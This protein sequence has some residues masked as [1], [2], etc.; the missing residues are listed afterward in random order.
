MCSSS[1]DAPTAKTPIHVFLVIPHV[2]STLLVTRGGPC[3]LLVTLMS[4]YR[5]RRENSEFI[6]KHSD[7]P[8]LR[9]GPS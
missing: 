6:I 5:D 7:H 4:S 8:P 3:P 9:L 2:L 1:M